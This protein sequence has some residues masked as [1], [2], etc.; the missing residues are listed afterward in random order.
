[1]KIAQEVANKVAIAI[2][3]ARLHRDLLA[4]EE[5]HRTLVE[6]IP[7]VV[8]TT[9]AI[10]MV[11][12]TYVSPQIEGLTGYSP[13]D[14]VSGK[15][16]WYDIVHP[17]DQELLIAADGASLESGDERMIE[18]RLLT[19]DGRTIWVREEV[20]LVRDEDGDRQFWQGILSDVTVQK[21]LESQ[22]IHQAFHDTLTGLPNRA[23]FNDR[24][25]HAQE[26]RWQ[27]GSGIAVCFIDLDNF[28]M[29]NDSHGHSV[30][31]ALLQAVAT[32][33]RQNLRQNDT[34]ARLGGD[35]FALLIEDVSSISGASRLI[36]RVMNTFDQPFSIGR[37]EL[38]VTPSIGIT[39][40][41][42]KEIKDRDL[43]READFAM[44][45]AKRS[46][47]TARFEIFNPALMAEAVSRLELENDLRKT[48]QGEQMQIYYQPVINMDVNAIVGVEALVRWNH[49]VH[50]LIMPD[51]FIPVSEET[52]MIVELGRWILEEACGQLQ[53]WNVQ[54]DSD[55]PLSLAVNLS[56]RQF[57]HSSLVEDVRAILTKTGLKPELLCLEITETVMASDENAAAAML[58]RLKELGILIA[59]DDFG[60]GYSSLTS[61]RRFPVDILKID[62]SFV[63]GLV[64]DPN[65][66]VIVSG[67]I[68]LAHALGL[69]VIAEGV[70]THAQLA[71]LAE[72]Q[73]D[74]AQGYYFARPMDV[75]TFERDYRPLIPADGYRSGHCS[76][77]C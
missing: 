17:A 74:L 15:L 26:R 41:N 45:E 35:E 10:D 18:Y 14:L 71:Q 3:N 25:Q 24:V 42:S 47:G 64:D 72:L 44:Y 69:D 53:E 70:E 63:N 68:G 56:A 2:D 40:A 7:A 61:L 54:R 21:E 33:L 66:A 5:R 19:R 30:G 73:C 49:P 59:I 16:N 13:D 43:L 34:A 11:N 29:V 32:R 9:D 37:H 31:D 39:I 52:G 58:G 51:R 4:S 12:L 38:Y 48:L 57:G 8:F 27:P 28:K 77:L 1:M 76:I 36:S 6:Q 65:D 62:R 22:L 23:L 55:S 50:G 75:S 60:V 20:R 46:G 67:V